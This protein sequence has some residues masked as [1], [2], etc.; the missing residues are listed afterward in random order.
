MIWPQ[1]YHR[2]TWASTDGRITYF[3][4]VNRLKAKPEPPDGGSVKP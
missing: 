2:I 3:D 1:D 4:Q